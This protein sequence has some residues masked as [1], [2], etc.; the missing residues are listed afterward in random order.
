[1][2][3]SYFENV[4]A[5]DGQY[6]NESEIFWASGAAMVI[7]TSLFK[8]LGGFDGAYFAHME[9]IDLCWRIKR[10][11]YKIK[12]IPTSVVYHLGGGT[13]AYENAFKTKLNFRNSLATLFKNESFLRLILII[14][15]RLILDGIAGI[16][17]LLSGKWKSC[18]AIIQAHFSFY[19]RIIDLSS[20][21]TKGNK[22]I[23][24]HAIGQSNMV[25]RTSKSII[26]QYYILGKKM[27]SDIF[28]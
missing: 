3:G 12:M 5:D 6:D 15:A 2:Q 14:P 13:L 1:M 21:R 18:M 11:G 20:K 7:R 10:A 25:G 24:K 8:N 22:A 28:K 17:F 26:F 23:K 19:A 4:E 9:E 27:Y 16:K